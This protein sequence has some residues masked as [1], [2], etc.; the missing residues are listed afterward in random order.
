VQFNNFQQQQQQQHL[1]NYL[2]FPHLQ[3]YNQIYYPPPMQIMTNNINNTN[4][5]IPKFPQYQIQGQIQGQ[6]PGHIQGQLQGLGQI[7]NQFEN[8]NLNLS[9]SSNEYNIME[10]NNSLIGNEIGN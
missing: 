4:Q 5:E 3:N 1:K 9:L 2:A 6:V 8:T 7:H 10:K